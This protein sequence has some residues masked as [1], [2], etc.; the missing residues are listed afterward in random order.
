MPIKAVFFDC[1]G[2]ITKVRSSWEYLHRR[3]GLWDGMADRYERLFREG[4]IDYLEFCKRDA[5]LWKGLPLEKVLEVIEEIELQDGAAELFL[6][7]RKMGIRTAI[8]STGLSILVQ[9]IQKMLGVDFSVGNELLCE[10]GV[11]T[12]EIKVNVEYGRKGEWVR[13]LLSEW[14]LTKGEAAAIG[15]GRGDEDMFTQV[16]HAIGFNPEKELAGMLAR[17]VRGLSLRPVQRILEELI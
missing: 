11:I 2:T 1:D 15:D 4:K 12:G 6:Y 5:S 17:E 3:L 8:I 16:G 9:R 7:L 10:G 14:S 13:K